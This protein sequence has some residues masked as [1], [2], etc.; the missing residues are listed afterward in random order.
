MSTPNHPDV[1]WQCERCLKP[2]R[3]GD[4]VMR[5]R[6]LPSSAP[7]RAGAGS[8]GTYRTA[9]HRECAEKEGAKT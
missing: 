8:L 7:S 2:L 3:E 1:A 6:Q 5:E 9:L 4:A